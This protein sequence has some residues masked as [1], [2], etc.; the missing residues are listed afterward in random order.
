M[1]PAAYRSL[2][3]AYYAVAARNIRECGGVINK[4]LGDGVFALF[5]PGFSGP[6]HAEHGIEAARRIL[7][8][9]DATSD[10]P[11]EA[12]PLPLGIGVHTGTA[13]VGVMGKAGDLLDFTA[14][15]DAVNLTQRLSSAA[16]GR[17]LLISDDAQRAARREATGLERRELRLRGINRPVVAWS[18]RYS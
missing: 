16:A 8:D 13:Y 11:A 10:L 15:G 7:R 18:D 6:D 5:V 4:Y 17:E 1:P 2:V 9:T 12:A 3:N 14:I